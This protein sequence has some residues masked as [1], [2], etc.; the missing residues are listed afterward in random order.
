MAYVYIIKTKSGKYYIGSTTDIKS[1]IEHHKGGHTLSTKRL[2]FDSC[3]LVQEYK[4]L[5][6][7]RKIESKLKKFK[8]RDFIDKIVSEGYIRVRI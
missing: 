5:S 3:V 7:A 4:T 8:R 2:G 1:R 6:E